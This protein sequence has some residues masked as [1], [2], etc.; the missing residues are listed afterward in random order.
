VARDNVTLFETRYE[1]NDDGY[2]LMLVTG[3]NKQSVSLSTGRLEG[4]L[5]ARDVHVARVRERLD[6]IAGKLIEDVNR[7]HMQGRT[8]TGSG[9]QFFTGDNLHTIGVNSELVA[10]SAR[11]ATGRTTAP[12]DNELALAIANLGNLSSGADSERT[13]NDVYRMLLTDLASSRSSYEFMVENQRAVVATLEAKLA[14]VSGVSL[15][16]EGASMVRYQNAYVAAAKV[17]TTVQA[18]YDT[19]L[20]M[21]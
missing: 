13:V 11:V 4:L 2:R 20:S 8:L 1:R 12:G 6:A 10:N 15:D 19:L 3:D 5:S 18:M 16:E 21:V 14:A 7:L 9:L 17:V